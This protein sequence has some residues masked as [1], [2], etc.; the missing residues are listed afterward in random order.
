MLEVV[1]TL[2]I[3]ATHGPT[4]TGVVVIF[5]HVVGWEVVGAISDQIG[6]WTPSPLNS[7]GSL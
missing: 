6:Y 2:G 1:G 7:L 5:F 4:F 3:L